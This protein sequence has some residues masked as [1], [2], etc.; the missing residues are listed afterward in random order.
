MI[1]CFAALGH[2]AL[3]LKVVALY[4]ICDESSKIQDMEQLGPLLSE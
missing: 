2:P 1:W 3:H 4:L